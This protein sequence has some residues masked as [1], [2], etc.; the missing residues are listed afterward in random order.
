VTDDRPRVDL[1]HA[2]LGKL[3]GDYRVSRARAPRALGVS[4]DHREAT[5]AQ[6]AC[7]LGV[8]LVEPVERSLQQQ[9]APLRRALR[10]QLELGLSQAPDV[11]RELSAGEHVDCN[12]RSAQASIE[13][14]HP[15]GDLGWIG[16][17]QR[18]DVWGRDDRSR[19]VRDRISE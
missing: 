2:A 13:L 14:L 18:M 6:L 5:L 4:D 16:D 9:P 10:D 15:I 17:V 19:A 1:Q 12:P 8:A 7:G 3:V 11:E